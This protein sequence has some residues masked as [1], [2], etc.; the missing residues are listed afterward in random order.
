MQVYDDLKNDRYVL[1]IATSCFVAGLKSFLEIKK[2]N[3]EKL[4]TVDLIC[5]GTP[6]P[7]LF[8]D[9]INYLENKNTNW[10]TLQIEK[11]D[12]IWKKF[13]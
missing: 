13:P 12:N 10:R 7:R 3:T 9:Y 5:H 11:E 2:C 6:S 4:C 1:Y 8:R